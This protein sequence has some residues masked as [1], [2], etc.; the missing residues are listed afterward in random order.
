[1]ASVSQHRFGRRSLSEHSG[2]EC[3][4]LVGRARAAAPFYSL[5]GREFLRRGV[6]RELLTSYLYALFSL[7][8]SRGDGYF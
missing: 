7:S 2:L 4:R 3:I 5:R 8:C 6:N 1:M